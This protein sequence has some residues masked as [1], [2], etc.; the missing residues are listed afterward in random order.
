MKGEEKKAKREKKRYRNEKMSPKEVEET[1]KD[2]T[3]KNLMKAKEKL[4]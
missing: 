2:K 4:E 3:K 1:Y